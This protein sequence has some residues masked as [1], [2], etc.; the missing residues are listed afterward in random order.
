[1]PDHSF[2]DM[3]AIL[4]YALLAR[5]APV[6]TFS[7]PPLALAAV[8]TAKSTTPCGNAPSLRT[9]SLASFLQT[10]FFEVSKSGEFSSRK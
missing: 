3:A 2:Q 9:T 10:I 4:E 7:F 5:S 8:L 1:M 6:F